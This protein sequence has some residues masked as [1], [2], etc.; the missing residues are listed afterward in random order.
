[1]CQEVGVV[2]AVGG[3]GSRRLVYGVPCV[4]R[5]KSFMLKRSQSLSLQMP[6]GADWAVSLPCTPEPVFHEGFPDFQRVTISGDYCAGVTENMEFQ[7][8]PDLHSSASVS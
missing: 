3:A 6:G 7:L 2:T 5:K 1:M 4:N 8:H